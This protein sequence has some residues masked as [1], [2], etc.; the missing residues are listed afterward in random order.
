ML[1]DD[2]E[3]YHKTLGLSGLN[4]LIS[5]TDPT[6]LRWY[7]R[8][9][10]IYEAIK[11]MLYMREEAIIYSLHSCLI[12]LLP[13]IEGPP[14]TTVTMPTKAYVGHVGSYIDLLGIYTARHIKQFLRVV[15]ECLEYPDYCG[16]ETRMQTLKALMML[17]K[18]VWP[19]IPCHKSEIIKI[20]L[21]L[22]SDLCPQ[23][24][25][26]PSKPEIL[27]QL[28]LVSECLS[29]LQLCCDNMEVY[30]FFPEFLR[31]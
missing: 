2:H 14:P 22:V 21:K 8:A 25:L 28:E 9:D 4:H 1:V 10:V 3:S 29:T 26:I 11:S 13:V 16:E 19:R 17:M 23:E 27:R 5:N 12:I 7:G 30:V 24:D 15:V 20:L 18:H 31:M 6:E